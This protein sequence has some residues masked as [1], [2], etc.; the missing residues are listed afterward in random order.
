MHDIQLLLVAGTRY[1]RKIMTQ[2]FFALL[3]G[4]ITAVSPCVIPILP[5]IL[6]SALKKSR[7]YPVMMILGMATMFSVLGVLF[8]AFGAAIP[9]SRDSLNT[10]AIVILFLMGLFILSDSAGNRLSRIMNPLM[11]KCSVK[12]MKKDDSLLD[13]FFLGSVLGVVWAPCAGPILASILALAASSQSVLSGFL[14]LFVYSIGAGIPMLLIAYGG[15]RFVQGRQFLTTHSKQIKKAFAW[16]L[17]LTAVG[18]YFGWFR[19]LEA[20]LI[21]YLPDFFSAF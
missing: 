18:L 4:I 15:R 5:I 21:P 20:L 16:I 12:F 6:S 9:I 17:I 3:A 1:L 11:T 13:G 10:F 19:A 14:L 2:L 7:F 8:G